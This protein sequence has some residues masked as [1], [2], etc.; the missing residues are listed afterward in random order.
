MFNTVRQSSSFDG[1]VIDDRNERP[2]TI[3][4]ATIIVVWLFAF[5]LTFA[6]GHNP[7][8]WLGGAAAITSP[9]AK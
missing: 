4:L 3:A 7:A 8:S 1:I 6:S 2:L 9:T 5:A